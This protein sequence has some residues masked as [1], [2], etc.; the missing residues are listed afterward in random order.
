MIAPPVLHVIEEKRGVSL[1]SGMQVSKARGLLDTDQSG[2]QSR[3]VFQG[4]RVEQIGGWGTMGH[5]GPHG[6]TAMASR[7][8]GQ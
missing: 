7:L 6:D 4:G 2:I 5:H 3:A 1:H 8:R